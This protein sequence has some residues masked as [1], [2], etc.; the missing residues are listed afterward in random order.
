MGRA[1]PLL[2]LWAI[3]PVQS[4]SACTRVLF[5]S[6]FTSHR[7]QPRTHSTAAVHTVLLSIE[8]GASDVIELI[9]TLCCTASFVTSFCYVIYQ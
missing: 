3:R 6:T 8:I 7:I 1:I 4:L 2:P 9:L 5:T